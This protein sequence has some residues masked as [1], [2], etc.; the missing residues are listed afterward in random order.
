MKR[1][2]T[3]LLSSLFSI[4]MFA[5]VFSVKPAC[6]ALIYQPEVPESLRQ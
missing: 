5:A 2:Y 3:L 1:I 4:L 6:V